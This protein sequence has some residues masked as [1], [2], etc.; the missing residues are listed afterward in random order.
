[1]AP[2]VTTAAS[3]TG[4]L[5]PS[6]S[7][8]GTGLNTID[9]TALPATPSGSATMTVYDTQGN[10]YDIQVK[11]YKCYTDDTTNTTSYYWQADPTDTANLSLSSNSGFIEFNSSGKIITTD[12]T[13]YNTNPMLTLTPQG[14]Y[15][16]SAA[17]NV[18]LDLS[19][20]SYYTSSSNSGISVGNVNG[21]AAGELQDFSIG[22]D[23]VITGVYSNDQTQPLGMLA[24]ATFNNPS[25]LEKI[26]NNLYAATVNSG[27][28][29]GGVAAGSGGS[30]SLSS[31]TLEMSNV[32]LSDSL[33]EMMIAQR[34]YQAN[35]KIIT[36]TDSMLETVINMIR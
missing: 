27:G 33:S 18:S 8:N 24:L 26:G 11:L 13:N 25:G 1:M 14:N 21:Y 9:T 19:D 15:S 32:D 16:G 31:G 5:D 10:D 6:K 34:A 12:S 36:T 7:A 20:I 17:F 30:G 29:T 3:L 35:S 4:N 2:S 23:G 28:F 22:A